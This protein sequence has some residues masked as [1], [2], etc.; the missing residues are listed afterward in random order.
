MIDSK[1]QGA[2]LWWRNTDEVPLDEV[3]AD[4]VHELASKR[5]LHDELGGEV[6]LFL[7]VAADYHDLVDDAA[8]LYAD[9]ALRYP[10]MKSLV[11]ERVES[12]SMDYNDIHELLKLRR[13]NAEG[14]DLL[15]DLGSPEKLLYSPQIF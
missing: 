13:A 3:S 7:A 8:R 10:H 12:D 11:L 1:I 5:E 6:V 4:T 2:F 15:S 14:C 9:T